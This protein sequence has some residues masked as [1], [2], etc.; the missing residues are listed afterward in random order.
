MMGVC[1]KLGKLKTENLKLL[2][3]LMTSNPAQ[4]ITVYLK[5]HA[6]RQNSTVK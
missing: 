3:M 4:A 2:L 6:N 1:L 5:W